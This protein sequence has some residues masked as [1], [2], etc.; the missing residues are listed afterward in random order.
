MRPIIEEFDPFLAKGSDEA[1]EALGVVLVY[2]DSWE[3]LLTGPD[4]EWAKAQEF[5][6]LVGTVLALPNWETGG[7]RGYAFGLGRSDETPDPMLFGHL[8]RKANT[9]TPLWLENAEL[10]P[11]GWLEP[12]VIAFGLGAYR[13]DRYKSTI[14]GHE[15]RLVL[16]DAELLE[17]ARLIVSA[18]ALARDMINIPAADMGPAALAA[19]VEMVA[20]EHSATCWVIEGSALEEE[21]FPMIH[22]VGRAGGETP[23]LIDMTW[24]NESAP[25]VTLVGKGVTFDTG[26]LDL[27][28]S[29]AMGLMKKDMGGAAN[30]LAL[31]KMI[32]AAGLNLRLRVLIPAVENGVGRDAF[33][34]GD[35]LPSRKGISVA[36]GNTDAEGR[37]VLADALALADEEEP[38]LMIDMATLTGAA[39]VALGPDLPPFYTDDEMLAADLATAAANVHDP[40]W[41]LPLWAP[42]NDMIKSNIAD[43][44]NAGAGGFAGSI[45]AALFLKRFVENATAYLHLD[46]YGWSPKAK[47]TGPEGGEA[48][49]IRA[50]FNL[51]EAR[52]GNSE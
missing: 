51:L 27:K 11:V 20:A 19:T 26:G 32:M 45:T 14:T 44:D 13:F 4:I 40:L 52:Y 15:P 23:R 9:D 24:G 43:I 18:S 38:E 37:L 16:D 49:G 47:S 33:R 48:Q 46:I 29:S 39:R 3:Q 8:A 1:K 28:P 42:Y 6:G 36:I 41:R 7:V 22:A 25:R 17:R 35:I 21:N 30:V 50:I 5:T 2:A 34:P 12:A 31:A 10:A